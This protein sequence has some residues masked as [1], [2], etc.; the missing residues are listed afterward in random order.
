MMIGKMLWRVTFSP[1]TGQPIV[2]GWRIIAA[3]SGSFGNTE[4]IVRN[5][6][7][8]Y[9]ETVSADSIGIYAFLTYDEARADLQKLLS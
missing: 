1:I 3:Q 4:Y 2:T 9:D 7:Y 6:D 8:R 5:R